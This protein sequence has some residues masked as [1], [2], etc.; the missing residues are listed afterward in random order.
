MRWISLLIAVAA[1]GAES[2]TFT[3]PSPSPPLDPAQR[4]EPATPPAQA[5]PA[6]GAPTAA[7]PRPAPDIKVLGAI[8]ELTIASYPPTGF[9]KLKPEQRLLAYHLTQA[10]LAGDPIFT[11]HASR[12]ALPV[13]RAVARLL[14]RKD[15]LDPAFRDKLVEYRFRLFLHHGL[16]DSGTGQKFLPS[17]SQKEIEA[18]ARGLRIA[19]PRD[20]LVAMFD[21]KVAPTVTSKTPGKG[22]DPMIVSSSSK[23]LGRVVNHLE[24]AI[25][26]A[27][28][29]QND[30][31]RHLVRYF[32]T[33]A[34]EAFWHHDFIW[35]K[36]V[37]PVDYILG[38]IGT[39]TDVRGPKRTF[40]GFVAIP[41]PE[42]DAPLQ[43]LSWNAQY[44]E[45]K[46]PW[47]PR[48][49][50]AVF[51]TPAAAAVTVLAA[52]GGA[53]PMT[54]MGRNLPSAQNLRENYGSK[55]FVVLSVSDSRQAL[56]GA[57][58][59]DEFAPAEARAEIHRCSSALDF[60]ATSLH[61]IIG[62]GAGKVNPDLAADPETLLAPYSS[63]L[64]E[65]R[66]E[67]V[68]DYLS[69]DPKTV[70]IGL[71]PD[72]GCARIYPQYRAMRQ[73]LLLKS[74]PVGD[75][76]ETDPLRAAGIA[77]G[78]L[79]DKGAVSVE[80]REGKTFFVVKDPDAWHRVTGE[81][82]RE[83]QRIKATADKAALWALVERY[84]TRINPKW[85]D[86][87]L[88]R[89]SALKLPREIATI[90]P[91][92]TPVR[93]PSGTIVDAQAAQ[94]TDLAAYVEALEKASLP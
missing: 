57:K 86:E 82:L 80:E 38:F 69:E 20:L 51:R 7:T 63:T 89:L 44:F 92:L 83:H 54:F 52:T 8:G 9:D 70:E 19:I 81:L 73:L 28:P 34:P 66:A 32:K 88:A 93:D 13:T 18:A 75:V 24:E 47:D 91:I 94:T 90:P 6:P 64:E 5:P 49:K 12:D 84:G 39:S 58:T 3:P 61:E 33:G 77:F 17:F 65:G 59:I 62:H 67:L 31:L 46:M 11:M 27:P 14:A 22:K 37:F 2:C 41:D 72:A 53:G 35:L 1:V 78:Y 36:R 74:V 29:P 76:A 55:N 42:R 50:R 40:E 68:A 25:A 21:A 45:Q 48:W 4:G 87:V 71:L 79:K 16:H 85:R 23:E 10:A 60:A 26:V 30:A 56:M 43:A 15:Q